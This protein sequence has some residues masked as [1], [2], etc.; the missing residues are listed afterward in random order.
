MIGIDV[1]FRHL[2]ELHR[3]WFELKKG[4]SLIIKDFGDT[5]FKRA[6][7]LGAIHTTQNGLPPECDLL[8]NRL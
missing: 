7:P 6:S 8:E 2:I 1:F 4:F 5:K 3:V